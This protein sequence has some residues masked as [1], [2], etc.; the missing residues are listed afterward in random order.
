M[1][2]SP[3]IPVV[4]ETETITL[5]CQADGFPTPSYSWRFNGKVLTGADKNTLTFA[6][7]EVKDAG[8]YTCKA[9]NFR[10]SSEAKL[11]LN[12]QCE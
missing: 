1:T 5:T 3:A 11:I 2:I 10:G 4:K 6:S 12:V 8:N 9:Q 7:A